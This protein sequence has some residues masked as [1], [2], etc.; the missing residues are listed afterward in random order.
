MNDLEKVL[1]ERGNVTLDS[2]EAA[3]KE[4]KQ[5][6]ASNAAEEINTLR[7]IGL[8]A[9]I[10]FVEAQKEEYIVR[11]NSA[12]KFDRPIVSLS[13]IKRLCLDFRLYMKPARDY[14]GRIPADLGAE[15]NRF[16]N[17]KS[18]PRPAS[19]EYSNFYVIAPPK[20]F[21]GYRSAGQIL[22]DAI[23]KA[24]RQRERQRI[25]AAEDP[26]LVFKIDET[27]FAVIKSWGNDFTS[28]RRIM[29]FVTRRVFIRPFLAAVTILGV[30]AMIWGNVEFWKLAASMADGH[31]PGW[32]QAK[33]M[34]SGAA[35]SIATI[36]FW[37]L[38]ATIENEGLGLTIRKHIHRSVTHQNEG[39]HK[40]N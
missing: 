13:E 36:L 2:G 25:A 6:L 26:I 18:I 9:D 24:E 34:L 14:I 16:C 4:V 32:G 29:G 12:K 30:V 22:I 37:M 27:H 19:S 28:V 33:W 20:M 11:S 3:V 15:L 23:L 7:S 10:K 17:E 35:V 40:P 8:D 21:K 1:L 38:M 5:L 39:G 31:K